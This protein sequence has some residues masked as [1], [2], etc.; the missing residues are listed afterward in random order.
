LTILSRLAVVF[1][2]AAAAAPWFAAEPQPSQTFAYEEGAK[3][4]ALTALKGRAIERIPLHYIGTYNDFLGPGY[5]LHLVQLEGP[6]AEH[7]G[8]AAGM[9][10]SPVYLGDRLIGALSYRLGALPKDAIAGVTPIEAMRAAARS[11]AALAPSSDDVQPIRTPLSASGLHPELREWARGQLESAGLVWTDGAA[12]T[13]AEPAAG[14]ASIKF[15]PGSPI[16]VA[17]VRG[18]WTFA[19]T[20]TVTAVEEG[21]VLAFGHPFMGT[22]KVQFPMHTATVIHTLA[23]AA[24]SRKMAAIGDEVGAIIDDRLTAVVGRVGRQATMIPLLVRVQ[25]AGAETVR[26]TFLE[27]VDT[28]GLTPLLAGLSVSNSILNHVDR[29]VAVTV[30][31]SGKIRLLAHPDIPF[32]LTA[33]G[34]GAVDPLVSVAARVQQTLAM[35]WNNPYERPAVVGV[36]VDV[37]LVAEL[38]RYSVESV[39]YDRKAVRPGGTI[40]IQ[41]ALRPWRGEPIQ[42]AFKL[43]VPHD[44]DEG[45]K[46]RL[47]VGPPSQIERALGSPLA[48]RMQTA[49]DLSGV[50][51]VLGELRADH[52]LVAVLYHEAPTIVRGGV[53]FSQLPPTAAHLLSSGA[54]TGTAFRSRVSRLASSQ[55]EM[56]GPITGGLAIRV[57][58]D[59][60]TPG[61]GLKEQQR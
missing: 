59:A 32:E 24:G 58:V 40:D 60:G 3:G 31:A 47:A 52:R 51:R 45:K 25:P 28:P 44:V 46:L 27:I 10:G 53:A 38:N 36:E 41:V 49:S 15:E 39:Y 56:D 50:L 61:D 57:K 8:I 17:L 18:A 26:E 48:R 33:A 9:S 13:D 30:K 37:D 1:L 55:L 4:Y 34:D 35:L 54:R 20:G 6:I 29:E 2:A 12:T 19:A 5:D 14:D 11:A 43:R 23:D 42:K 22:G 7:V 21:N 16:G